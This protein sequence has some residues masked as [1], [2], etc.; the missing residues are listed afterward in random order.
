MPPRGF[1]HTVLYV[2]VIY[3]WSKERTRKS[4]VLIAE[5]MRRIRV[6]LGNVYIYYAH[7]RVYK[8][9]ENDCEGLDERVVY[10]SCIDESALAASAVV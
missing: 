6:S 9:S 10:G 7:R 5:R 1:S 3:G 2:C 8:R 4:N